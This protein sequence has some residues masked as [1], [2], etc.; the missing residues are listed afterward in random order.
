MLELRIAKAWEET[1]QELYGYDT[2][3]DPSQIQRTRDEFEGDFTIVVFPFV[4]MAKK[5]PDMV[6][7]E[8]GNALLE[9]LKPLG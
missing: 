6:A 2:T 8:I 3:I 4:K 5:A 1:L 9:K 7:R